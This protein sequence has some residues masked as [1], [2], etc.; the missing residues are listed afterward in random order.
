MNHKKFIGIIL[1]SFVSLIIIITIPVVYFL[2]SRNNNLKLPNNTPI[3]NSKNQITETKTSV[4]YNNKEYGFIFSLPNDWN[5]YSIVEGK[6]TGNSINSS[7]S[8]NIGTEEGPM[9]SIRNPKWTTNEPMQDIPIMIFT[10]KQW[11]SLK[12]DEFHIGAAPINPS[13]LNHNT[14]YVFALPARYNFA[15]PKGF[16]EV[17]QILQN[18]PLGVIN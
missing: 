15:F 6:W 16:E 2:S 10:N 17:E 4:E 1:I 12:K 14:N 13:E 9:I 18:K 3:E 5:N 8:Q 11:D 7:G